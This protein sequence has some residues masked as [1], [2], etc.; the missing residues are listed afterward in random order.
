MGRRMKAHELLSD[1]TKWTKKTYARDEDGV[2]IDVQDPKACS[3]C[4]IGAIQKCYGGFEIV[5]R[6]VER[7]TEKVKEQ[8]KEFKSDYIVDWNDG[9]DTTFEDIHK[10]LKELDI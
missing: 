10:V 1:A 5:V 7:V 3:F 6:L 2:D 4:I 8:N 9:E